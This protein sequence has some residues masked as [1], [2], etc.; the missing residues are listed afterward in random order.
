MKH[1]LERQSLKLQGSAN[2]SNGAREPINESSTQKLSKS[3]KTLSIKIPEGAN[4]WNLF[5][6][7]LK[8]AF[9]IKNVPKNQLAEIFSNI[10][11]I[12][13]IIC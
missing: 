6:N 12:K 2:N 9:K 8:R 1:N 5:F 7:I 10:L 13:W 11:G 4:E 3:L